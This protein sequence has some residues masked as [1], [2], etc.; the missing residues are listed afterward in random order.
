MAIRFDG[1]FDQLF[2]IFKEGDI[3]LHGRGFPTRRY[4]RGYHLIGRVAVAVVIDNN[5]GSLRGQI[6]GNGPT[7]STR[8]SCDNGDFSC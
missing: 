4:N 1:R 6:F 8:G 5:F 7:N 2:S 3:G